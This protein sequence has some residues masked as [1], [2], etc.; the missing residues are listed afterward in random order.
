MSDHPN[1]ALA[2]DAYAAI[3]KGDLDALRGQL[4]ADDV[5]F[6]IPGHGPL[7]GDRHG[8]DEVL[9]FVAQLNERTKGGLQLEPYAILTNDDYAAALVRVKGQREGK[10]LQDTGVHVFRIAGGKI[11]ERWSYPGDL[12]KTDDFFA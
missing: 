5:V 12:Y 10:A 11:A 4:L 6:H 7:G 1:A 3:A 2:R 8:K 9:R